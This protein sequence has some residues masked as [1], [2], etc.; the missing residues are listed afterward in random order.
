MIQQRRSSGEP[1]P[2][3]GAVE[4]RLASPCDA[5]TIAGF[6]A[7]MAW[8]TEGRRLIS[9][10]ASDGVNAVMDEPG[11]GF[12]AVAEQQGRVV[13]ALL[14][15]HEWSDWRNARFWWIQS[16]YVAPEARRTGV[17]RALHRFVEDRARDAGNVCGLRLYV[18]KD[19]HIAQQ[20]YEE[21][22]MS[23][24]GYHLYEQ[25]FDAP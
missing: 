8:E 7:R 3:Q 18:E 21:M 22:G 17:Y 14:V 6:N 20:V 1:S 2:A 13:G 15:T 11:H 23:D 5:A 12:Y 16:V 10:V 19:N 24:S 9:Q 4:V 25:E